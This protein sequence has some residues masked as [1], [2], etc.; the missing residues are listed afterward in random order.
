MI[1]IS[2]IAFIVLALICICKKKRLC[3]YRNNQLAVAFEKANTVTDDENKGKMDKYQSSFIKSVVT[4]PDNNS[5][6]NS[7]GFVLYSGSNHHSDREKI[8]ESTSHDNQGYVDEDNTDS[9]SLTSSGSGVP[10]QNVSFECEVHSSS[11]LTGFIPPDLD[12]IQEEAEDGQSNDSIDDN[13]PTIHAHN[14]EDSLSYYA[15]KYSP[16]YSGLKL[17]IFY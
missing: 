12:S 11:N 6:L 14:F 5:I 9:A 10:T 1:V 13:I 16:S 2:I 8:Y 4:G 15:E 7:P 17:L 3:C